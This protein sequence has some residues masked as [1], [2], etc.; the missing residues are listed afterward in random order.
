MII[1]THNDFELM[2]G[3]PED[4]RAVL[5]NERVIVAFFGDT[6]VKDADDKVVFDA[7]EIVQHVLNRNRLNRRKLEKELINL[8]YGLFSM[9]QEI[10]CKITFV[11]F[12]LKDNEFHHSIIQIENDD[13]RTTKLM[14]SAKC[15]EY[16]EFDRS[17]EFSVGR[18]SMTEEQLR[19]S[20]D[21]EIDIYRLF[22]NEQ[23]SAG[24]F[25]TARPRYYGFYL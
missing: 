17:D 10:D 9:S 8:T 21:E 23:A 13:G 1:A 4:K 12:Y 2:V 14:F 6:I 5:G 19:D 16:L 3:Y 24:F 22:S 20:F 15:P 7:A 11:L 25:G 18:D